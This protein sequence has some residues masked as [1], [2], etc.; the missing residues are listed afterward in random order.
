MG[1][2][3][4]KKGGVMDL[5]RRIATVGLA[6]VATLGLGHLALAATEIVASNSTEDS[7]VTTGDANSQNNQ[8]AV[9]G[10]NGLVNVQDGDNEFDGTQS[11]DSESGDGVNGQVI[12]AVGASVAPV[13]ARLRSTPAT[14]C[15]DCETDDGRRELPE[16]LRNGGRSERRH[17]RPGRRQRGRGRAGRGLR[18]R[19]RRQRPGHRNAATSLLRTER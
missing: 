10:Q 18:V 9:V 17:Q 2:P 14:S 3:D 7:D 19:R 6:A 13:A 4:R 5:K 1:G 11:A 16:Q 12:G 15:E 8:A